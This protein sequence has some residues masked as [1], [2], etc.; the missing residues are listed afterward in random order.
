MKRRLTEHGHAQPCSTIELMSQEPAPEVQDVPVTALN[1]QDPPANRWAFWHVGDLLPTYRVPRGDG[2]PRP[3]P[4]AAGGQASSAAPGRP[5]LLSVPVTRMDRTP[6]PPLT[7]TVGDVLD[8][9]YTDAYLVLQD[10]ALVTEWYGPLGA[11][12]RPHA[13]SPSKGRERDRKAALAFAPP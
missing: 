7:G 9:T 13:L 11:P 2:I 1:W 12:D 5:D 4:A 3:L 10:G 8:D 6:G